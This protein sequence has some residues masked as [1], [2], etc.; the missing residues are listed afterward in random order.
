MFHKKPRVFAA[1]FFSWS[2]Y[3]PNLNYDRKI[4]RSI[5]KDTKNPS[6][7]KNSK[8]KEKTGKHLVKWILF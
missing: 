8:K 2:K 6:N 1:F 4:N 7:N 5:E 3:G